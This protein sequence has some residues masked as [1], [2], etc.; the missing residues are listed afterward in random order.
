VV[1]QYQAA[2]SVCSHARFAHKKNL[3]TDK[4]AVPACGAR[5]SGSTCKRMIQ[6]QLAHCFVS[7]NFALKIWAPLFR[8]DDPVRAFALP[9]RDR[10]QLYEQ[11]IG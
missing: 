3:T 1:V 7:D 9:A 11:L 4:F 8:Q 10:K 5:S 2:R 6:P